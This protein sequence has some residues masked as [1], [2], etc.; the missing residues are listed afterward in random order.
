MSR[1]SILES[2]ITTDLLLIWHWWL[3]P[4]FT[5][6][7]FWLW[8]V[9]ALK[10]GTRASLTGWSNKQ[11]A[12]CLLLPLSGS[13]HFKRGC[14]TVSP[15][16]TICLLV[17][18]VQ[19]L[20]FPSDKNCFYLH[21][22][23]KISQCNDLILMQV[24]ILRLGKSSLWSGILPRRHSQVPQFCAQFHPTSDRLRQ[25]VSEA[26]AWLVTFYYSLWSLRKG[27]GCPRLMKHQGVHQ[28]W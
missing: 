8:S 9:T 17:A 1:I 25:G 19:F 24:V 23:K 12:F 10:S 11:V 26:A 18:C 27:L 22:L 21:F 2:R 14:P 7:L 5:V 20:S 28:Q 6:W 4:F 13:K 15:V 3:C 16:L